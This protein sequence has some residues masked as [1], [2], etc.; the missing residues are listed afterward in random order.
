MTTFRDLMERRKE[1]LFVVKN[2]NQV[3]DILMELSF[4]DN[5]GEDDYSNGTSSGSKGTKYGVYSDTPDGIEAIRKVCKELKIKY[6][7]V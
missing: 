6:T 7:E 4:E 3:D 1:V 2:S 5:L